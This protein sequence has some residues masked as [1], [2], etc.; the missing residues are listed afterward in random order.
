MA[1]LP[2]RLLKALQR[3]LAD[4]GR[5]DR[6][7]GASPVGGGC[8]NNGACVH[9]DRRAFFLKWNASAPVG[10]FEAE[11]DGLRAL[12]SG[13]TLRIPEPIAWGGGATSW[14]LMEYIEP[15]P[16]GPAYDERLGRGLAQLH[17]ASAEDAGYGWERANWI[18][19]L[20]QSN[21]T[22]PSWADFWRGE[23]IEPQLRLARERGLL[24]RGSALLDRLVA[25]VASALADVDESRAHLLHGDLWSGNAFSGPSGEPVL[26]D[27]A[28]YRGHGEV[29]LAMTELFGGFGRRF[30]SAYADVAGASPGYKA[31]R[32]DL[33][34]LYYLLVHV[35]LFGAS[36]EGRT[37]DGAR[38]VL[39]ELE[40]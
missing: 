9:T 3:A 16:P 27:P 32:R 17:L 18:G 10:M 12:G 5:G 14:L 40:A 7:T 11:V 33:Y 2:P 1:T 13:G 4:L 25:S 20:A 22:H 36:Y 6:I 15:A 34:Q 23:R 39:A 24:R 30:Y 31:V 38:R 26:I 37:L 8:I 28:V 29:D 19:S 35:N 21:K